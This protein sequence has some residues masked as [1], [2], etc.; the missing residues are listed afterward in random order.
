MSLPTTECRD[1]AAIGL[2]KLADADIMSALLDKQVGAFEAVERAIPDLVAAARVMKTAIETDRLIAYAGA[3]SSGLAALSDYLELPGTFGLPPNRL[4]M[5]YAGGAANLINLTG[6]AED[7]PS[8]GETDLDAAG[9]GPGDCLICVSASG[10]TPYTLGTLRAAKRHGA[11]VIALASNPDTPLLQ[12]ADCPVLLETPAEIIAGSTRM[13]AAT[14]QKAAMNML[15]TLVALRL[16]HVVRGHMINLV[17]DNEKLKTR[18]QRIVC[19]LARCTADQ[20]ETALTMAGGRVKI[21]VLLSIRNVQTV[22]QAETALAA[23]QG[24]LRDLL[25][26]D[27]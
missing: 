17:A 5:L 13:G 23:V 7:D 19:D 10:S 14:A 2:S 16:G 26:D 4:R 9:I 24:N 6:G 25:P 1:P 27:S 22:E 21:A 12:E 15:S 11:K 3:G 8:A 18:A 20:A